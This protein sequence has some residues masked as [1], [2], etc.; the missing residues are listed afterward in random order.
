[1]FEIYIHGRYGYVQKFSSLNIFHRLEMEG[2][3]LRRRRA[4]EGKGKGK[5]REREREG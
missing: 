2:G 4:R 1:L 5:G 3:M